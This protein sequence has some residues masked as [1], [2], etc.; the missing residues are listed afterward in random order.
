MKIIADFCFIGVFLSGES[1]KVH[2]SYN[3]SSY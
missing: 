2:K 3:V 1:K